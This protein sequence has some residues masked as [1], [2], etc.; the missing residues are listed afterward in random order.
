MYES[1]KPQ[2]GDSMTQ[3]SL[4]FPNFIISLITILYLS[5]ET[6]E[7]NQGLMLCWD[8]LVSQDILLI[9]W[10]KIWLDWPVEK[11]DKKKCRIR[12]QERK[13]W[14]EER[15][16]FILQIPQD[17]KWNQNSWIEKKR[18]VECISCLQP[19]LSV[20]SRRKGKR[21][22]RFQDVCISTKLGY[23]SEWW[24]MWRESRPGKPRE[25]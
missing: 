7:T 12:W 3:S 6:L 22:S 1:C 20:I 15:W 18:R 5:S 19:W 16:M 21:S 2:C 17:F 24:W 13:R 4:P 14:G 9:K 10:E 25:V 23:N 8:V 11:H